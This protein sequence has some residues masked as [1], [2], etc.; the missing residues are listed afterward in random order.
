M[1]LLKVIIFHPGAIV[2]FFLSSYE[3]N[4]SEGEF[5]LICVELLNM[6]DVEV[7]DDITV[8]IAETNGEFATS[9]KWQIKLLIVACHWGHY[10][11]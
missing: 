3:V 7:L 4:E 2:G 8:S 11:F 5:D 6:E 9:G 1:F 10:F